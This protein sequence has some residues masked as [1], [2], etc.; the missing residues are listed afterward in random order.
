M[1]LGHWFRA[2][3]FVEDHVPRSITE[4]KGINRNVFGYKAF[5]NM[6]STAFHRELNLCQFLF[7]FLMG[8]I[9]AESYPIF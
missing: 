7:S 3:A 2:Q 8:L 4:L 5:F 6:R 1:W 9:E